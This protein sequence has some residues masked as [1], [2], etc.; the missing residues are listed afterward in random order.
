M[1]PHPSVILFFLFHCLNVFA[2]KITILGFRLTIENCPVDVMHKNNLPPPPQKKKKKKKKM[3]S[4]PPPLPRLPKIKCSSP[5]TVRSYLT[6]L[7]FFSICCSIFLINTISRNRPSSILL[8]FHQHRTTSASKWYNLAW[9][10]LAN[11]AFSRKSTFIYTQKSRKLYCEALYCSRWTGMNT[12][13]SLN[14]S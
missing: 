11:I 4:S 9:S 12:L 5:N 10:V 6:V 1:T 14:K 7:I 3:S 8:S 13:L 2:V